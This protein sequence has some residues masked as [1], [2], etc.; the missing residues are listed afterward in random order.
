MAEQKKYTLTV[1]ITLVIANMIGTGV[2]TSLGY[3]VGSIPSGFAILVLWAI[4]GVVALSGAFTYAEISTTLQKSGGEYH[5]LGKIFHPALGFISG[6]MSLLVGFAG[7][8]SAVALA[9]GEYSHT[10]LGVSNKLI[11]IF[12]IVLVS[13]VHWFGVKTGGAVQ[14]FL[15]SMKLLLILFFCI[16]PFFVADEIKSGI[17][18]WPQA[19][20]TD[21]ILSASFAVSLVFVVYAYTG[22]NAAA[23]IAGNLENPSKNLPRSLIIGTLTV[24]IVYLAL[25]AMFLYSASFS[26]LNGKNDIGNVVAYKLFGDKI[27]LAFSSVFS[28]ALL[29]TLSAMTIA[30]PRV[31]EAMGDDYPKL[32]TFATTNRFDM[33]YLAILTQ[34]GW[35]IFLVLVSSFKEIIQYISVSL[36]IFSMATV[37]GIFILRRKHSAEK[38][39]YSVPF[40]PLPPIIFSVCT[41]WMIYYV[42]KNDPWII[43]YSMA[44]MVPGLIIYFAISKKPV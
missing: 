25:N 23:Y 9:I 44:T 14:N 15:T 20:D 40:Y 43:L 19:G 24:T 31:L 35:A 3:Q 18:F 5:Y 10:L 34:A 13:T 29:S 7:A 12:A 37:L 27:G 22:W 8:I 16:A 2:F 30:G 32:K 33:P 28:I 41:C 6:W 42:T 36:S 17:S 39:V 4:G 38:R 21:L 1:G 26:E 11:A